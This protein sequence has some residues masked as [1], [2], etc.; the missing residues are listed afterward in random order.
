LIIKVLGP[1][2]PDLKDLMRKNP[3]Y[4][5]VNFGDSKKIYDARR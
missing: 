4:E 2:T 5:G 3:D 1:L